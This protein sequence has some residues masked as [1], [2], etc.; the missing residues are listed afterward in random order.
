M[1][2]I[3]KEKNKLFVSIQSKFQSIIALFI[4][5]LNKELKRAEDECDVHTD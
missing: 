1:P 2:E 5:V 4:V 3:L